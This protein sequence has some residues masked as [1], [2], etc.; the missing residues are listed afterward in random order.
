MEYSDNLSIS[1]K[2]AWALGEDRYANALHYAYLS[3]D[4]K[5]IKSVEWEVKRQ[6]GSGFEEMCAIAQRLLAIKQ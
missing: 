6:C 5:L 3:K 2:I 1:E 4:S